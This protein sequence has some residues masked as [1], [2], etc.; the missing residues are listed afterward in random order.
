M[1]KGNCYQQAFWAVFHGVVDF[2][3]SIVLVHGYPIGTGGDARG[4][5]YGHAW[6]EGV[7]A[8]IPMV[9]DAAT[10]KTFFR[11]A[12][13]RAGQIKSEECHR[14]TKKEAARWASK[15]EHY[16]PWESDPIDISVVE[17]VTV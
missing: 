16:G 8:G 9:Y 17:G 13:Y 3:E 11:A 2:G 10:G 4:L 1:S 7:L 6:V 14:Y 12:Y 5:K 15:T